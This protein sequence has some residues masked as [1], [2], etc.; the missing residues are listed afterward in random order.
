MNKMP[1]FNAAAGA[2]GS[3]YGAVLSFA[4]KAAGNYVLND[5]NF[6]GLGK[7]LPCWVALSIFNLNAGTTGGVQISTDNGTTWKSLSAPI[8]GTATAGTVTSVGCVVFVDSPG[9]TGIGQGVSTTATVR[10]AL[11]GNVADVFLFPM[12]QA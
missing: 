5:T 6:A 9:V 12:L 4:G 3:P 1:V 7:F 8:N 2:V 10:I 11:I